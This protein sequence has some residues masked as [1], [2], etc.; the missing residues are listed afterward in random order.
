MINLAIA[1]LVV[2]SVPAI[3][4]LPIVSLKLRRIV[5][6]GTSIMLYFLMASC[7]NNSDD[8]KKLF[9]FLRENKEVFKK[10]GFVVM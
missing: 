5:S 6:L 9:E 8:V 2:N 1:S 4:T 10:Y 3:P 7:V